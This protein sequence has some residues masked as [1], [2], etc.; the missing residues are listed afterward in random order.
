MRGPSL[1]GARAALVPRL[2]AT[3]RLEDFVGRY[4]GEEFAVVL[5]SVDSKSASQSA[6]RLRKA[7]ADE[8]CMWLAEDTQSMA[9]IAV[10]G[11]IGI[12]VYS[13]HGVTREELVENADRA[14]Y[15]AKHS[16]RNCVCIVDLNNAPVETKNHGMS[17]TSGGSG[18]SALPRQCKP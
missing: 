10:T 8:P 6:E 3:L 4:G 16:G 2:R 17:G 13:L 5:T 9:P 18:G 1:P 11:S 14:M 12:A 7:I 15:K